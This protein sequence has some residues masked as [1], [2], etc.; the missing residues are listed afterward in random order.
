MG[1]L[2]SRFIACSP[3]LV[4]KGWCFWGDG[5]DELEMARMTGTNHAAL[6]SRGVVA[7]LIL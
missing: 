7:G 6:I 5:M 1:R 4:A 3:A 2:F